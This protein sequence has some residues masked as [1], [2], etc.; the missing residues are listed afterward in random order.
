MQ[1]LNPGLISFGII[2]ALIALPIIIHLINLMRYRRVK[3]AAM[4][5]L[6]AAHKK[7]STWILLKQLLLL[8]C[9]IAALLALLMVLAQMLYNAD[10]STIIS[11]QTTHHWVVIDDTYSMNDP[12]VGGRTLLDVAKEEA[13][14]IGE[15]AAR[16]PGRHTFTLTTYTRA[17]RKAQLLLNQAAVDRNFA[18]TLKSAL[19][20][21]TATE[22]SVPPQ[23]ALD[24]LKE[25]VRPENEK[26]RVYLLSDFRAREWGTPD[27]LKTQ[28]DEMTKDGSLLHLVQ[29]TK[30]EHD[31]L[32]VTALKPRNGALAAGISIIMDVSVKNHGKTAR[33]NV[34]IVRSVDGTTL[35]PITISAI[36][37]GQ[38]ETRS[39]EVQFDRAGSHRITAQLQSEDAVAADNARHTVLEVQEQ[40]PVL[41]VDGLMGTGDSQGIDT[42]FLANA[43]KPGDFHT[44]LSPELAAP[45]QLA[46]P[47]FNLSK[48]QGVFLCNFDRLSDEAIENL[49]KYVRAGGGLAF[50]AGERF[51]PRFIND[52]L[53]KDG[54]GLFPAPLAAQYELIVDRVDKSPDLEPDIDHPVFRMF[55]GEGGKYLAEIATWRY[56]AVTRD[57]KP[58]DKSTAKVIARLRNQAPL[59]IEHTFDNGGRV[60][61]VLTTAGPSWNDWAR[62]ITY[63]V[64]IQEL[65]NYLSP[66]VS[67]VSR[68]VGSPISETLSAD[69]YD[70][71]VTWKSANL[72]EHREMKITGEAGQYDL[73]VPDISRAGIYELELNTRENKKELKTYVFNVAPEEGDLA[74]VS[75]EKLNAMYG[76]DNKNIMVLQPGTIGGQ[77]DDSTRSSLSELLLYGLILLLICEQM[78]AYS[79]SYHPPVLKGAAA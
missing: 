21:V 74:L 59:V 19:G 77:I 75:T 20:Q 15:A 39:F 3:W 57:W 44:G 31:N 28:F 7:S 65:R 76:K 73:P 47:K 70:A 56:Y 52:K 64:A 17:K 68:L 50:F 60:V 27:D 48:Y 35:A 12:G 51:N 67:E 8:L 22:M 46:N 30:T 58:D 49:E 18:N 25:L 32:T 55:G 26:R 40:I 45:E 29:C 11:G 1:F 43:L 5:F 69:K 34:S 24:S 10:L 72:E 4:E 38:T 36:L 37:P 79:A 42:F 23:V 41:I 54:H 61:A 14:K 6:L 53:Y 2:A 33:G 63:L 78:L 71:K 16:S 62:H 9:R 13:L 66:P